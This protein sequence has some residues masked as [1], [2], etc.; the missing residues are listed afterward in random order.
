MH[1]FKAFALSAVTVTPI[2]SNVE[3]N[4]TE[5]PKSKSTD[6]SS[7]S[8]IAATTYSMNVSTTDLITPSI[9]MIAETTTSHLHAA[10]VENET[11]DPSYGKH[12]CK[13]KREEHTPKTLIQT[14]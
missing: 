2:I 13:V 14:E 11:K 5:S 8:S 10:V 4:S 7:S 1:Y 6:R 12:H 9:S 3:T